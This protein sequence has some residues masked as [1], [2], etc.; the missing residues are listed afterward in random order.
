MALNEPAGRGSRSLRSDRS[1]TSTVREASDRLRDPE[2]AAQNQAGGPLE[3]FH[4]EGAPPEGPCGAWL[5]EDTPKSRAELPSRGSAPN[6]GGAVGGG[7]HAPEPLREQ[8]Q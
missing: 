7:E 1:H 4:A 6:T 5:C 8:R 2:G 3:A